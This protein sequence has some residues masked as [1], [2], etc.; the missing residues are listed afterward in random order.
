M[1]NLAEFKEWL[2][3][4]ASFIE[5]IN[6]FPN[7]KQ[8]L[9]LSKQMLDVI[10]QFKKN[11]DS[12][13]SSGLLEIDESASEI[14]E[15]RDQCIFILQNAFTNLPPLHY[16]TCD[17]LRHRMKKMGGSTEILLEI[18]TYRKSLFD[19]NKNMFENKEVIAE[20]ENWV[21]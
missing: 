6:Q 15:M 5:F 2:N 4:E 17:I 11:N 19:N 18:D 20:V 21:W 9:I 1:D 7:D 16:G 3:D 12:L 10:E 14:S 13:S 8:L